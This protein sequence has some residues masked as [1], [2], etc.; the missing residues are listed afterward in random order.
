M[1]EFPQGNTLVRLYEFVKSVRDFGLMALARRE[2][3]PSKKLRSG[4]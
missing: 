3:A 2:T 4:F 1:A